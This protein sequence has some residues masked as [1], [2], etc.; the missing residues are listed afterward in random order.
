MLCTS[1]ECEKYARGWV[2]KAGGGGGEAK[3]E[4]GVGGGGVCPGST[5]S[6][7]MLSATLCVQ[8]QKCIV[9]YSSHGS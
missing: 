5:S 4:M 3:L 2:G 6:K 7:N 8:N 1:V 9:S